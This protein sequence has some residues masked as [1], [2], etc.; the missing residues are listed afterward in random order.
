VLGESG[1]SDTLNLKTTPAMNRFVRLAAVSATLVLATWSAR[2]AE[3]GY[4]DLG[5]FQ[6]VEGCQF[7]EV[8]VPTS[9][10]NFAS[11]FA[12]KDD[13][14]AAAL[15]RQ[16]K[17]VRV[18]VVGY[19]DAG[20]DLTKRVVDLRSQLESKGWTQVVVAKDADTSADVAVFTLLKGDAIEGVLVTVLDGANKQAV[21]VNVVGSINPEQIALLGKR[22]NIEPLA[23]LKLGAKGKG[24]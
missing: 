14:E 22:L 16:L 1:L 9:L 23:D 19:K 13:A 8:N 20:T 5:K 4:V 18:N 15:I 12:E 3:P 10:L 24:V 21:L 7:V 17:H 6:P 11:K 2:A